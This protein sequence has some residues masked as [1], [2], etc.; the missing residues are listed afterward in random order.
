MIAL[1]ILVVAAVVGLGLVR[2]WP[3]WIQENPN[4]ILVPQ[5]TA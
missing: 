2:D 1:G 5:A 3:K 4:K